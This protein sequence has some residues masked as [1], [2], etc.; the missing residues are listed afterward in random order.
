MHDLINKHLDRAVKKN[1][2]NTALL[3]RYFRVH[4]KIHLSKEVLQNRLLC[5]K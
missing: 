2:S 5:L 1:H 3:Q 4:F